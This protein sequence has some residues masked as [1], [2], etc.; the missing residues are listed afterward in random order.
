MTAAE[1]R[2]NAVRLLQAAEHETD[3]QLME[4]LN[5]LADSWLALAEQLAEAER[6]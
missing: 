5:D 2:D 3:R 1:A 4:R 6:T